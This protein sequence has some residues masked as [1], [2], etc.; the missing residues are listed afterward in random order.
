MHRCGTSG[1]WNC[2][3]RRSAF[4]H[5][6]TSLAEVGESPLAKSVTSCPCRT[7]S[8]VRYDTTRSVPPYREG[9]TLSNKGDTWAIRMASPAPQRPYAAIMD[10]RHEPPFT[11]EGNPHSSPSPCFSLSFP[12]GRPLP[13]RRWPPPPQPLRHWE[14]PPRHECQR[15]RQGLRRGLGRSDRQDG[16]ARFLESCQRAAPLRPHAGGAGQGNRGLAEHRAYFRSTL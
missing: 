6:G 13:H 14:R 7:S 11:A 1:S 8:S 10:Q 15:D 4:A 2:G 9:G 16:L 5:P 3:F 12:N